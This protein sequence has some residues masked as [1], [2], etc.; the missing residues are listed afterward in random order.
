MLKR[1]AFARTFIANPSHIHCSLRERKRHA[2][3]VI[4]SEIT[5][6]NYSRP[7]LTV[8]PGAFSGC[9]NSFTANIRHLKTVE[10]RYVR[11]MHNDV[12][13]FACR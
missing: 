2:L 7:A 10:R 6:S 9:K 13:I 1:A 12:E 11:R 3:P 4:S 8:R 5:E